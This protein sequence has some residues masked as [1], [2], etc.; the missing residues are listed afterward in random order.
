MDEE[1]GGKESLFPDVCCVVCCRDL[2]GPTAVLALHGPCVG[3][4][5]CWSFS[6]CF[7]AEGSDL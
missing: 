7:P 4:C 1:L 2:G 5:L 3:G 6:A